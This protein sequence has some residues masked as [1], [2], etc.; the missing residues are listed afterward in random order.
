F[1]AE[2]WS[3][4]RWGADA[5]RVAETDHRPHSSPCPVYRGEEEGV[6]IRQTGETFEITLIP[7]EATGFLCLHAR[8]EG[9]RF[10]SRRSVGP[11][12]CGIGP[13]PSFDLGRSPRRGKSSCGGF[14]QAPGCSALVSWNP[15]CG[16][17][18]SGERCYPESK[19]HGKVR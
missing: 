5:G 15:P 4:P 3:F 17:K 2:G 16:G 7:R 8:F 9:L 12:A 1:P 6:A 13:L 14:R 10:R 11:S 19:M 18:Q